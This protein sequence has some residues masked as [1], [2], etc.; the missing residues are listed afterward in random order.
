MTNGLA[1]DLKKTK[2]MKFES[3]QQNNACFHIACGDE[4]TEEEMNVKFL[5]LEIDK[6]MNCKTHMQCM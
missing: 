6:H 1:L 3:D 2:I 5:G 4:Q